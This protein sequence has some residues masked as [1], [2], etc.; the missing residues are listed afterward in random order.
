VPSFDYEP[1]GRLIGVD[2]AQGAI[3]AQTAA[4]AAT[5]GTLSGL[6]FTPLEPVR[7]TVASDGSVWIAASLS[8]DP[9]KQSQSRLVRYDPATG[10]ITG[11]SGVYLGV[12]L[13]AVADDGHVPDDTTRPRGSIRGS[14]ARRHGVRGFSYYGPIGMKVNEPGQVTGELLLDGKT[15]ASGFESTYV[16]GFVDVDFFPRKATRATLHKAAAAHRRA[17]VRMTVHDEA[18]NKRTYQQAVRLSL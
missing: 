14:V 18:G 2:P 1:D 7:A 9:K 13:A 8:N 12:K 17:V 11:V 4:G 5:V 3:A 10:K 16:A 6:A 15:V